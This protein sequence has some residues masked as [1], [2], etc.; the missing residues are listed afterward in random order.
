MNEQLDPEEVA[1]VMSRIKAESVRLV[2]AYGG[3]SVSE[4]AIQATAAILGIALVLYSAGFS[5]VRIHAARL[6]VNPGP[7]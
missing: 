4:T 2:E 1:E 6:S 7:T 3:C 5:S